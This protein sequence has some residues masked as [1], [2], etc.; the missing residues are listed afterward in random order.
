MTYSFQGHDLNSLL[1]DLALA[2][3]AYTYVICLPKY[4]PKIGKS[5]GVIDV[6]K[7]WVLIMVIPNTTYAFF[8]IKHLIFSDKVADIPNIYS[9]LVFGSIS[10]FGFYSA[11]KVLTT[12]VSHYAKNT[13]QV[14]FYQA[15]FSLVLGFGTVAG[16][17]DYNSYEGVVFPPVVI[18]IFYDILMQPRMIGIALLTSILAFAI[19]LPSQKQA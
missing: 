1:M 15:F 14:I 10:L 7:L 11:Y 16:L 13:S 19:C 8:E 6:L 18:K 9:Y 12:L 2:L 4:L 5:M 17:L 3:L